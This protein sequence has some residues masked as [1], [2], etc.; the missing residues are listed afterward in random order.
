MSLEPFKECRRVE[1]LKRIPDFKFSKGISSPNLSHSEPCLFQELC[2]DILWQ[3]QLNV[4]RNLVM[5]GIRA[6]TI[7]TEFRLGTAPDCTR[8][9]GEHS[10]VHLPALSQKLSNSHCKAHALFSTNSG[11][12]L[13]WSVFTGS[14]FY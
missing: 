14:R 11:D 5:A 3:Q 1:H 6:R 9:V 2:W 4:F 10:S 12:G 8:V 13:N 7:S